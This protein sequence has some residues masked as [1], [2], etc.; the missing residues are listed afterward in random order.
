MSKLK[1]FLGLVL[2]LFGI[3]IIGFGLLKSYL[4]FT[5]KASPPEIFKYKTIQPENQNFTPTQE[6]EKNLQE[7]LAKNL[8][9]LFPQDFS[10]KMLNLISWAVFC[11]ILFYGGSKIAHIGVG[12]LRN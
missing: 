2:I 5:N 12:L 7:V 4:I 11:G 6:I 1:N 3:S 9:N 8:W 10:E